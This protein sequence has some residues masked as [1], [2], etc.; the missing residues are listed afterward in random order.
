MID[1]NSLIL[2]SSEGKDLDYKGPCDWNTSDK[3]ARCELVK[4]ILALA[5]AGGGWLVIGVSE[6][7]TAFAHAGVSD[8]Q[9]ASFETTQVNT[10]LN[11]YADPPINTRIHKPEVQGKRFVAIEVPGFPDTPHICQ[12]E[13]PDVL[14]APTLYVRTANNESAP[15]KSSADFRAIVERATRNRADSILESVRA[16]LTHGAL[17]AELPDREQFEAQAAEARNW[18]DDQNPHRDK[19]YGYRESV[20]Y[21][22]SFVRDRFD[23]RT[24]KSMALNA[25]NDFRG[26]PFL[27]ASEMRHDLMKVIQDGHQSALINRCPWDNSDELHFWQL[28]QSGMLYVRQVLR[29]DTHQTIHGGKRF[30]SFESF[31]IIA[32]EAVHTLVKL[33]EDRLDDGDEVHLWLRFT[34]MQDR[35]ITSQSCLLR[36]EFICQIPEI[37]YERN[38]PLIDWRAGMIDHALDICQ[39]IFHRFNWEYPALGASRRLMEKAINRQL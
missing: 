29:E 12:K 3:R 5:N 17:K 37:T 13:Y 31:S 24:L 2:R 28:R 4:D 26:W 21:P 34:E 18:C 8:E 1:W 11:N 9:A 38:L 35:V 7:R 39:H 20:F 25:Y 22:Q 10:F 19:G 23:L 32:F 36:G 14:T 27:F 30:L 6:T 33:Y 16:L 15:I